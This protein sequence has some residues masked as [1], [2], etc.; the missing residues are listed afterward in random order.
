MIRQLE[1]SGAHVTVYEDEYSRRMRVDDY[2]GIPSA[3]LSLILSSIPSW[4]EKLIIKS[5]PNDL[6]F[7]S[8][9]GFAEEATIVGY[10]SGVTMHFLTKYLLASRGQSNK[11]KLEDDIIRTLLANPPYPESSPPVLVELAKKSD[12]GELAKLYG[13]SFKVY[14][15]PVSDPAHVLMTMQN[16]TVYMVVRDNG[17]IV[18]A[19]SAEI[20]ETYQNA[21][22]TDCATA[23]GYEGKGLMRALLLELEQ[24]L[25]AHEITCL[26]TI[27]RSESF[28][29]N[30]VFH[31][32]GY[33]Y[34]GRMTKN[35][36]IFSGMEDMNVWYKN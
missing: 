29:M 12:A 33:T 26:Y 8:Q 16:G 27:A 35:C 13:A 34:G 7:F 10:F 31:Q 11:T 6:R 32:L 9:N 19:A 25:R 3:V 1:K 17:R 36:I 28:G 24:S 21:E 22:L 30:K 15:T 23:G 14:P 2:S 18:S 4:T 20:N 5:K